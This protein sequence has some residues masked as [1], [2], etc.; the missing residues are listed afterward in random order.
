MFRKAI[1]LTIVS[2]I[3]AA[4]SSGSQ[5]VVRTARYRHGGGNP[6]M[7]Y[8]AKS[9]FSQQEDRVVIFD[10]TLRLRVN[11][12]DSLNRSLTEVFKKYNGYAVTL[13]NDRSTI[14]V[15]AV[16]LDK[17][18]TDIARLGKLKSKTLKG[19]DVTDEYKDYGIRLDNAE[20]ARQRYL[21]LL[22]K[23]ENVEAALKVE[24]ELERLN[25]EIESLKGKLDRLRHL[26]DFSTIDIYIDQKE[27]LGVLGY[28]SVGV[29]K[30]VKWLFVRE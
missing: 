24:K 14:R 15:G 21:E 25:G 8:F 3:M 6:S 28:A 27:K 20:K 5:T 12:S 7:G 22:A 10:A 1:I 26:S 29:Y 9:N 16:S 4:C 17:A 23:A 2:V 11:N 19:S 30:A 13:G 18:I